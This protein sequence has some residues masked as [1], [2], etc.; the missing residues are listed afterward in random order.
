MSDYRSEADRIHEW[1]LLC[2]HWGV[3]SKGGYPGQLL[4]GDGQPDL[5]AESD[6]VE[7]AM[8]RLHGGNTH[9]CRHYRLI[10][11]YY[12]HMAHQ[13]SDQGEALTGEHSLAEWLW[14]DDR[15]FRLADGRSDVDRARGWLN[16]AL[17]QLSAVDRMGQQGV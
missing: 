15:G 12:L 2:M 3:R 6:R 1:H 4:K 16:T 7:R 5:D 13:D 10:R 9:P 11:R 14:K 17:L 8:R